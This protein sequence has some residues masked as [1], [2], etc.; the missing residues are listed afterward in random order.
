[1][2]IKSD[3][4]FE[5]SW[6]SA[7]CYIPTCVRRRDSLLQVTFI[8]SSFWVASGQQQDETPWAVPYD[9]DD[10]VLDKILWRKGTRSE[11]VN[12]DR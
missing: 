7:G 12:K 2:L 5:Q 1:M 4:E 9:I 11:I 3:F 10:L 6:I 8:E